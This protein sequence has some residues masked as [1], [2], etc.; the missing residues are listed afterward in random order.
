MSLE[1]NRREAIALGVAS[2]ASLSLPN[3]AESSRDAAASALVQSHDE[4]LK[5]LL[6]SQVTD[7]QSRWCGGIPDQW[8][9]HYCGSAAGLLRDGAAA[10]FH[11]R[12]RFQASKELLERMKLAAGF[13]SRS[14][15]DE[16]NIDLLSTN[17]NSPPDTGFVVHSVA[18]AAKLAKMNH[19]EAVMSLVK[20]FLRRA[21]R[22]LA[23]GGI[24]TPNHRWVVCA[25]LAQ[26]N[27]LFPDKQYLERIDQWLAEGID[28]DEEG[29]FTERST[30]GYNT[31]VD[32]A[33][34]VM[35]HKLKRSELLDP[36]R[37]NLGAMAYLLHPNGEVVTEISSRQDLNTRGTMGGYW[38][39]LRYMAIR[40]QN[41]LYASMLKPLEP[42]H[43]E[44]PRL[45]EYP[46]LQKSLP[47]A[48][49]IPENY[50]REYELSGITRIRRGRTSATILHNDNSRWISLRRGEAVINAIRF[51]SAFFGK[52]QFIPTS[53]E[54][55]ADG[56]YFKQELTG[57]YFQPITDPS[58]LPVRNDKWSDLKMKRKTT[59][60]CRMVYEARI[61]ETEQGFEVFINAQGTG[62]V[63]LAVEINL[64]EGGELSG[65]TAAPNSNEVFLLK[66]GFAEYRMGPDVIRFGPGKCENGWVEVRGAQAKLPGPSVY[67][68]SYTPFQHT[69]T[70]Q[71]L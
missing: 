65:V 35:A 24:H 4:K 32:T 33:L 17:F 18:A 11:P 58:L 21:G 25:A 55:R 10:Y 34:V 15:N 63:P 64:R 19:D 27:E 3:Q 59:Q 48:A 57:R 6:D 44:L 14:Q 29:Q 51:A 1:M 42:E 68:T 60:I 8:D 40:D 46:E 70:F 31:V 47:E 53:Y 54:K 12:S 52:G 45:M 49:S 61:R 16:G 67:L 71:T 50:E 39:V 41:G 23:K 5:H 20:D 9:I 37:K 43:I 56:F 69:L 22:G 38:F 26:I 28:V 66:D 13:L 30:A 62:N 7:P 2:I 36:V